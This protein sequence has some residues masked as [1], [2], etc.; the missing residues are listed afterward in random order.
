VVEPFRLIAE[1]SYFE[2]TIIIDS[3][4]THAEYDKEIWKN[5]Y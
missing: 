2:K 3:I 4:L 5:E 1:I